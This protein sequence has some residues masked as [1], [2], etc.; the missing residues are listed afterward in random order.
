MARTR[1]RTKQGVDAGAEP[2]TELDG[3]KMGIRVHKLIG[4][5]AEA[6][7]RGPDPATVFDWVSRQEY[8]ARASSTRCPSAP[9]HGGLDLLPPL[10]GAELA[11]D[12]HRGLGAHLPL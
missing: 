6:G 12:R 4:A 8:P 7:V 5:M 9:D 3:R 10:R 11:V 2:A 1:A